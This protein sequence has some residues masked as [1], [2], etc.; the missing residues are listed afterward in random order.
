MKAVVFSNFPRSYFKGSL[1]PKLEELGIKVTR[2]VRFESVG[3]FS[4]NS[5]DAVICLTHLSSKGQ[6]QSAKK[7]AKKNGKKFIVL[8]GKGSSWKK[9][10]GLDK[11]PREMPAKSVKD[12]DVPDLVN[13]FQKL[14]EVNT[15]EDEMVDILK[16]YWTARPLKSYKQLY[17]YIARLVQLDRCPPGFGKWWVDKT[18]EEETIS[19]RTAP[20][21]SV[22]PSEPEPPY[23]SEPPPSSVS[24][25]DLE[26]M[27]ALY[28]DD[29]AELKQKIAELEQELAK[30]RAPVSDEWK[31]TKEV[32][33]SIQRLVKVGL[34]SKEE[35]F[36]KLSDFMDK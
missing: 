34:M 9:Q 19:P 18:R 12:Q 10:L 17:Q 22:V 2:A 29:N 3:D 24:V 5:V 6:L 20:I 26:G 25:E 27:I 35:A 7:L 16:R 15:P 11:E 33:D 28:E 31:K 21:L 23:P 36:D 30:P 14:W 8:T 4:T 32:I 13:D 1:V